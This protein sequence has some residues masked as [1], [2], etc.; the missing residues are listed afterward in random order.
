[1]SEELFD[2]E[3]KIALIPHKPGCYIMRDRRGRIVYVGKAKDLK[4]RVRSY[5]AAS[6]GDTRAFVSRLPK[7]LSDIETIVTANE[8]EALI[9]ESTLVKAHLPKY[10]VLLKDDKNF[11]SL[12]IDT[13]GEWPRVEVVRRQNKDG[14]KYFGPYHAAKS[15]RKTLNL[16]NKYFQLRTCTDSVLHS[17]ERP[18]LQYQIKRCPGP[19]VFDVD[20]QL[21][22]QHV[23]DAVLFLEGRGDELIGR[24]KEQMYTASDEMEFERAA[25]YRD[26]IVSIQEALQRQT[27]VTT[28]R[29]DRDVLGYHREGDR[30]TVQVMYVRGGKL[31]GAQS[32]SYKGQEFPD[33]EL[34]SSFLNLY[35]SSGN[36]VPKEV[37]VP[38]TFDEAEYGVF[39]DLLSEMK[40]Q[41]V[42]VYS[43]QRGTKKA[44]VDTAN[45]NARVSFEKEHDKDERTQDLL[46][47]LQNRLGLRNYPERIECY[48]ISNFQGKQ[49]VGSMVVFEDGMP[50]KGEYRRYK[51][52]EV[53][54]QDDFASMHEILT[55]RFSKVAAGESEAP[56]LVVIDGGKGQLGQAAAVLQDLGLHEIDLIS[57]AK[58]RVD[59]VGFEDDEVTRST[60]RVFLPG[61]KN[62]IVLK[63]N[64]AELYLL[65]RIRDEA[66]RFAITFHQELRRKQSMKS[67]LDEIPGIGE[68][69]RKELLKHFGSLKKIRE[70]SL[71]EL[72]NAPGIGPKTAQSIFEFLN[73]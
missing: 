49:I 31:E 2:Y 66:H 13:R 21:Y 36:F 70:A 47:N 7:I 57:L 39:E 56:S 18:C 11:L 42:A 71:E 5:F 3:S 23:R 67:V 45:E 12:R 38:V 58:S 52:K 25:L 20:P 9:L 14:A 16:L 59:K 63:Q 19:C 17:R 50:A 46:E 69:T 55:R 64:S 41:R 68:K 10:N 32:F 43:P 22:A 24:L 33:V 15:I 51:M 34:I 60:E 61:R 62:P 27:A 48:D 6:T 29:V 28:E 53:T 35:Y 37:L 30:L 73:D 54:S 1:M 4:N 72:Q 26:Q 8:K 40:G 65:E 44:L